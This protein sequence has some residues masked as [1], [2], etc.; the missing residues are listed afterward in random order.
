MS[1]PEAKN[2][3]EIMKISKEH[4]NCLSGLLCQNST[5]SHIQ[6]LMKTTKS[7]LTLDPC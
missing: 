7:L 1:I 6:T 5:S 3:Q 4:A 2:Q